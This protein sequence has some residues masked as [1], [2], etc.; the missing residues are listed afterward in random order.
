MVRSI[1]NHCVRQC[2]SQLPRVKRGRRR[3]GA[4]FAASGEVLHKTRYR[5]LAI[6]SSSVEPPGWVQRIQLIGE[7]VAG[8]SICEP[9]SPRGPIAGLV[10]R[11][12]TMFQEAVPTPEPGQPATL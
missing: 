7:K 8:K 1:N 6:L 9:H 2:R 5:R 11:R 3:L 10:E 12:A 4:D